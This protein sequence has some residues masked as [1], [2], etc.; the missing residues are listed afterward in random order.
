MVRFIL[1]SHAVLFLRFMPGRRVEAFEAAQ[2]ACNNGRVCRHVFTLASLLER[3]D[4]ARSPI[5]PSGDNHSMSS[6][7]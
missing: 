5:D 2:G 6:T 3:A 4:F 7:R 1:G